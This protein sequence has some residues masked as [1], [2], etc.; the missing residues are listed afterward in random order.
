MLVCSMNKNQYPPEILELLESAITEELT[1]LQMRVQELEKM[2]EELLSSLASSEN[3]S[4]S[5]PNLLFVNDHDDEKSNQKWA[6]ALPLASFSHS[7]LGRKDFS[8]SFVGIDGQ[9]VVRLGYKQKT[10]NGKAP[11]VKKALKSILSGNV[12]RLPCR[13]NNGDEI[14][15][16]EVRLG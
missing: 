1:P 10:E 8:L 14:I 4:G 6:W 13:L 9:M 12:P 5:N 2:L 15:V 16:L 7:R 11:P 3:S